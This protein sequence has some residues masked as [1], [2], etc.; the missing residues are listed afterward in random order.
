MIQLCWFSPYVFKKVMFCKKTLGWC[1]KL[2]LE[3]CHGPKVCTGKKNRAAGGIG[4]NWRF[5]CGVIEQ[6]G[7]QNSQ[8]CEERGE[9]RCAFT[10]WY[11][12]NLEERSWWVREKK[13]QEQKD[14]CIHQYGLGADLLEGSSAEKNRGVLVYNRLAMSR[15]VP[16]WPRRCPGV[17]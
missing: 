9:M 6:D 5:C 13:L 16:L 11:N 2:R 10:G 1:R 15:K 12:I 8:G 14:R 17:H 4:M 3:I 7:M